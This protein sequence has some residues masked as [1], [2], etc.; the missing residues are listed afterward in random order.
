MNLQ[1]PLH[2]HHYYLEYFFSQSRKINLDEN[3]G[4]MTKL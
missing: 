2:L 3:M 1:N 4:N